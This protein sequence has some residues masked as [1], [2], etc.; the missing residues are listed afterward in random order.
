MF[1]I[2]LILFLI[3]LTPIGWIGLMC[4]GG[5]VSLIIDA[6]NKDYEK[7]AKRNVLNSLLLVEMDDDTRERVKMF[8][9]KEK[10]NG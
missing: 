6:Y 1:W 8:I 3:F 2:S 9:Q 5:C 7:I 4:L 10:R